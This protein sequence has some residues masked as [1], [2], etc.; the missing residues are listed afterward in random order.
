MFNYPWFWAPAPQPP[1]P[2]CPPAGGLALA[3]WREVY[4]APS[5]DDVWLIRKAEQGQRNDERREDWAA[6]F[7]VLGPRPGE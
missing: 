1:P 7:K 6:R 2:P 5:V 4:S 3:R